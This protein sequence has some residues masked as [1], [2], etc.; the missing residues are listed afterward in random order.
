MRK[1]K[2][3]IDFDKEEKWLNE[4]AKQGYQLVYKSFGYKFRRAEPENATIKVDYRIFKNQS[5]F[6]D[7]C[8][9]FEDSGWEHVAG[10]KSSGTQ[11]FKKMDGQSEEDIFSDKLSKAGK[12]KRLSA[13]SIQMA[14][15][16][17]PLLVVLITT[18]LIDMEAIVNPKQLYLTPGL[19]E[20]SGATF[21]RAFLFETPF[22][23]MRG[24]S[25]AVIPVMMILHLFFSYK[26][27]RLFE[28]NINS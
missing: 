4:M 14:T 22:A 28:K 21:W 27:N 2:F 26:A 10:K 12:Y 5:D 19:W 18:D 15:S 20:L 11:Y 9:L 23:L 17:L 8:T 7:Y 3:F 13:M 24:I 16:F 25:W 6:I 1:F